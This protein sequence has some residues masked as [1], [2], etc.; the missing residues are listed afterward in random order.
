[1][2]H[3]LFTLHEMMNITTRLEVGKQDYLLCDIDGLKLG[4]NRKLY[5]YCGSLNMTSTISD[6]KSTK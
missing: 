6:D 4:N 1:M 2:I 3:E 5:G